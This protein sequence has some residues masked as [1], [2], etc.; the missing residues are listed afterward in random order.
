[1]KIRALHLPEVSPPR[2]GTPDET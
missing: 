2:G 1:M